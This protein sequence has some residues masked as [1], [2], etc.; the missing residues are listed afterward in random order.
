VVALEAHAGTIGGPAFGAGHEAFVKEVRRFEGDGGGRRQ[1]GRGGR[2]RLDLGFGGQHADEGRARR[3]GVA[4]RVE[5]VGV[6]GVLGPALHG[7]AQVALAAAHLGLDG[8]GRRQR[9]LGGF[10]GGGDL[11]GSRLGDLRGRGSSQPLVVEA[12][13]GA[14]TLSG[15]KQKGKRETRC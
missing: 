5:D 13:C 8:Q 1:R 15:N 14:H 12:H 3:D 7:A 9:F 6:F 2:L 10:G 11:G 4:R